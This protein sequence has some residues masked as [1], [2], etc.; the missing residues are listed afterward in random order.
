[1][2]TA[3]RS[4]RAWLVRALMARL[5]WRVRASSPGFGCQSASPPVRAGRAGDGRAAIRWRQLQP[6]R[7]RR[8]PRIAASRLAMGPRQVRVSRVSPV[9]ARAH[10]RLP[11]RRRTLRMMW[12]ARRGCETPLERR[13]SR[14]RAGGAFTETHRPLTSPCLRRARAHRLRIDGTLPLRTPLDARLGSPSDQDR[15]HVLLV[16]RARTRDPGRLRRIDIRMLATR[17]EPKPPGPPAAAFEGNDACARRPSSERW[18]RMTERP[19]TPHRSHSLSL[20]GPRHLRIAPGSCE[21][22][23][24]TASRLATPG[25]RATAMRSTDFCHPNQSTASTHVSCAPSFFS[26]ACA[27]CLL[28]GVGPSDRLRARARRRAPNGLGP[29]DAARLGNPAFHDARFASA[30]RAFALAGRIR[31]PRARL[32]RASDTPV[33]SPAPVPRETRAHAGTRAAKIVSAGG[34]VKCGRRSRS[35]VSSLGKGCVQLRLATDPFRR[36]RLSMPC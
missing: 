18:S 22:G 3:D 17:V 25:V 12:S 35:E 21:P 29:L 32:D 7:F 28:E 13:L 30:D 1:L 31:H 8:T 11:R 33:A 14:G 16:R 5:E 10:A 19:A 2:S 6:T 34:T 36:R 23:H 4:Q 9:G 20:R 24:A 26:E 15:R 27:S